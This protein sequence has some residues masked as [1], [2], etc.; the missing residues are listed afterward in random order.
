VLRLTGA[1][2]FGGIGVKHKARKNKRD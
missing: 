2:I 1:C